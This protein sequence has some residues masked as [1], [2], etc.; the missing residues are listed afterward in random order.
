MLPPIIVELKDLHFPTRFNRTPR[1]I[2]ILDIKSLKSFCHKEGL[3]TLELRVILQLEGHIV[4]VSIRR[5]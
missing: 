3:K 2:E 1:T 5:K 4:L